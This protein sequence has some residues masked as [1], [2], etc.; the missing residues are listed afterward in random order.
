MDI[1][2][3]ASLAPGTARGK[4]EPRA[5]PNVR[6]EREV[7]RKKLRHQA[8]RE[9][10]RTPGDP[11]AEQ[12]QL[13]TDRLVPQLRFFSAWWDYAMGKPLSRGKP[14]QPGTNLMGQ[15]GSWVHLFCAEEGV[16]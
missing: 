16:W 2:A 1:S 10:P 5:I 13:L 7:L 11:G 3:W 12:A 6:K 9:S 8:R 15:K 14:L 4:E